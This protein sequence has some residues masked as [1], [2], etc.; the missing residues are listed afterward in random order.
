MAERANKKM[1]PRSKFHERTAMMKFRAPQ[2]A[3]SEEK[4]PV[5]RF[6]RRGKE[7]SSARGAAAPGKSHT[8]RQRIT[9]I[10]I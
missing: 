2:R 4:A 1:L 7:R 5:E 9:V 6:R 8:L 10:M 3:E